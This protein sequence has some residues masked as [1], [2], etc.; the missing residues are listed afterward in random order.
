M[1]YLQ[2]YR[3]IAYTGDVVFSPSQ[4]KIEGYY[5]ESGTVVL[6]K[7]EKELVD[8]NQY[9]FNI[10]SGPTIINI[11]SI[12]RNKPVH[13]WAVARTDAVIYRFDPEKFLNEF[14]TEDVFLS[15]IVDYT[16]ER[17]ISSIPGLISK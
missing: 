16:L 12:M 4:T 5:L 3:V 7:K 13:Y 1:K 8:P 14:K 15:A 10:V 6:L 9:A 2:Q 11:V 17:I